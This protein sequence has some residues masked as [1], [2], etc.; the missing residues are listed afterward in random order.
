MTAGVLLVTIIEPDASVAPQPRIISMPKLTALTT[1]ALAT[2]CLSTPLLTAAHA[3]PAPNRPTLMVAMSALGDLAPYRAI[4]ADTLKIVDGGDLMAARTRIKDLE[5][6]WDKGE[7]T[8]KPK[9]KAS[10]T[11]LDKAIDQ[12][13]TALRTPNPK[14]DECSAAL[15]A[16]LAKMDTVDK[17]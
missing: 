5:T 3:Q 4:A 17:A 11:T 16:L 12:A 14:A 6:A 13:L 15:K 7:S 9:D 1:V 2:A 8:L 10:W